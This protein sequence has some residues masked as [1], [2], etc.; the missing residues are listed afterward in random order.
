MISIETIEHAISQYQEE[1]P[2]FEAARKQLEDDYQQK[3]TL[4][5]NTINQ[6]VGAINALEALKASALVEKTPE[7]LPDDEPNRDW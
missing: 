7:K 6:V 3:R 1:L 5:V 2:N 4:I